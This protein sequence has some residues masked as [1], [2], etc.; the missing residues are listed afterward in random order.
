MTG[1]LG[2]GGSNPLAP[3]NSPEQ[4]QYLPRHRSNSLK[5]RIGTDG[6]QSAQFGAQS[7][8]I[9]PNS[10]RG[11]F[12]GPIERDRVTPETIKII[13]VPVNRRGRSSASLTE[14][15][16]LVGSSRQPFLNATLVLVAEGYDPANW[17]E[18]WRPGASAFDLRARLE[19]AAA[20]TVDVART[21]FAVWK[22]FSPSAV[23]SR[24][25]HSEQAATTP[26]LASGKV[27]AR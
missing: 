3:T 27:R 13:L 17:D 8:E 14:G 19:I 2:V 23:S 9:S 12:S 21:V 15:L 10:V 5:K 4:N 7:P 20:L 18:G 26:A 25:R 6:R 11:S 16:I 24:I 22:P 1:R